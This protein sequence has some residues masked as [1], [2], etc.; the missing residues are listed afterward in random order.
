MPHANQSLHDLYKTD[1]DRHLFTPA[2]RRPSSRP[3]R[4]APRQAP[5]PTTVATMLRVWWR[6]GWAYWK[7]AISYVNLLLS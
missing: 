5:L 7:G 1:L 2:I 3:P 6:S 4:Q